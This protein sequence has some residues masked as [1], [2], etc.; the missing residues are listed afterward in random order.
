MPGILEHSPADIV[1]QLLVDLNLG[2]DPETPGTG[3][4]T[5]WPISV[6]TELATP[7][8][9][10]EV[11]DTVGRFND[12]V[13]FGEFHELQGFIVRVR[14]QIHET[15]YAKAQEIAIALDETVLDDLVTLD[16]VVYVV[17]QTQRTSGVIALGREVPSSKRHLFTVNAV[18]N[19]WKR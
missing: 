12:S 3:T 14:S 15:G 7:D 19:V 6:S 18:V 4:D 10:I 5:D 8:D 13:Q 16:G 1:G 2:S 11:Y 17:H 9:A